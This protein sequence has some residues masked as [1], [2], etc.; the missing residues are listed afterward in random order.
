M[1]YKLSDLT[2]KL[3]ALRTDIMHL[4]TVGGVDQKLTF[5]NFMKS[6]RTLLEKSADYTILDTDI[7]PIIL[8]DGA[9]TD[10]TITLPTLAD[11]QNA[12]ITIIQAEDVLVTPADIIIDGEGAETING[13]TSLTF[14]KRH[15]S[16]TLFGAPNEWIILS[17]TW[18]RARTDLVSSSFTALAGVDQ[19]IVIAFFGL[20][21]VTIP[22]LSDPT[23]NERMITIKN[24]YLSQYAA[25]VVPSGSDTIDGYTL[26]ELRPSDSITFIEAEGKWYII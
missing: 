9:G 10:V 11:N 12:L 2:E 17:T 24:S 4:R 3:I 13:E 20:V 1:S 16:I 23:S 7:N 22:L 21:T 18:Q 26:I 6:Q 14:F 8:V 25:N 5:D 19:Y 15:D